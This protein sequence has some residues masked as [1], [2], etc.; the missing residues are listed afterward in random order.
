MKYNSIFVIVI[1]VLTGCS[2]TISD[3]VQ[4]E[5]DFGASVRKMQES[6]IYD[7]RTLSRL[8][9]IYPLPLDD[10]I[11][12][13]NTKSFRKSITINKIPSNTTTHTHINPY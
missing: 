11:N 10:S 12:D 5:N 6:Q 1:L 4:L 7:V 8:P 2:N 13:N 3:P 9:T